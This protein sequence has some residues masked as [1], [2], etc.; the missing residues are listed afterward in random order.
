MT[1][2]TE[3]DRERIAELRRLA[4]LAQGREPD[5]ETSS[6]APARRWEPDTGMTP[7]YSEHVR[8]RSSSQDSTRYWSHAKLMCCATTD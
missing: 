3:R 4:R 6:A 2:K 1:T 7:N 8:S 5:E